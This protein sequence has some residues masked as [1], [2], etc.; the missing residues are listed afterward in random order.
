MTSFDTGT[1]KLLVDIDDGTA[2]ITF[3][4]PERHNALS[5]AIRNALPVTLR[6]LQ[7]DPEVRVVVLTGAGDKA[8]VSGADIREFGDLR[9][10]RQARAEYDRVGSETAD[11]W[12]SFEKPVLAMIRGFCIGG[13]LLT[14]M[15]ADIRIASDDSQFGIPAARLGL[16]YGY[17]AVEELVR[18]V[19]SGWAAEILFSG[20][21]LNAT[22]AVQSGLVNRVVTVPEL[23]PAVM[24]L[25][26]MIKDNAPL[27]VAA[28]KVALGQTRLP[29]EHRDRDRLES[30]VE[31]CFRSN[32]Y[33]EGQAAF[34][35]KRPAR[36]TGR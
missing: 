4:Q 25:A 36:F 12:S 33:R 24:D 34:A 3:N 23:R 30:M 18:A 35:E 32:D 16:G 17:P 26:K 10:S 6:A 8:F 28:C 19:G 14:A 22:E 9:T 7:D 21:R 13:G 27:T 20:R 29:H 15:K 1:D 11:A 31:A 5:L 2:L